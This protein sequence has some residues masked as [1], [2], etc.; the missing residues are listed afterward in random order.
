M[1]AVDIT[2]RWWSL[3]ETERNPA[4]KQ[5]APARFALKVFHD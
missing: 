4:M 3:P 2:V 1:W 5:Q